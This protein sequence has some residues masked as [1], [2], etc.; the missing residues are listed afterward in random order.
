MSSLQDSLAK[1]NNLDLAELELDNVGSWPVP[2]KV[3]V[4][5]LVF[6]LVLFLGNYLHLSDLGDRL[7]REET[8]EQQLKQQFSTKSYMAANLEAYRSQ[9]VEM[10]ASFGALVKQLPSRTEV[11]GLL[12]D[13]S[14]TGVGAGLTVNSINLEDE[15][16]HEFYIEKPI[17]INV[18]GGYHDLGTFVSGVSGLPRIVTLH[19][20]SIKKDKGTGGLTMGIKARTYRY[21]DAGGAE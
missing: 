19:D 16:S 5:V 7:A 9:M 21:R 11:P 20:F 15:V 2:V 13:I 12:E 4:C 1:L 10:E 3:V 8:Q 14:Y 17:S 6:A 18:R